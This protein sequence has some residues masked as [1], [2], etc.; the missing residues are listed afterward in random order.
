MRNH[1]PSPFGTL[2]IPGNAALPQQHPIN[3]NP[4]H[5]S[6]M[7]ISST[8]G[9]LGPPPSAL[10]RRVSVSA[11]SIEPST[12]PEIPP[13]FYFK[14]PQQMKRLE[15]SIA[16][17]FLFRNLDDKK[18]K[19]V[20]GAMKEMHFEKGV[21][22]ITQ[23]DQGDY[24]Y[25]VDSGELSC[26]V[27]PKTDEQPAYPGAPPPP[28]PGPPAPGDHPEYGKKVFQYGKGTSFGELALMYSSPRAATIIS[29]TP[30]TLW[31]LD[32][33]TFK[34][35][36]L[37]IASRTR[38]DYESFLRSVP[39]LNSLTDRERAKLADV[40]Q[41]RE[42]EEGDTVV[43][44]GEVGREFYI[45]EEGEAI[46]YKK[47]DE[48]REEPV[49]E[50]KRGD[51]FGELALLHRAPRAATVRAKP[52]SGKLKVATLDGDAFTRLLGPLREL[53]E[54]TAEVKYSSAT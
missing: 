36:L 45:I 5:R 30:V 19:A 9:Y 15:D 13:P 43:K 39:L 48:E 25:V 53:M 54:R 33:V 41:P 1:S 27:K 26:Y 28:P 34:T 11:E 23:G 7:P 16:N 52:G 4:I 6:P 49:M 50:M 35:I 22:V 44:E 20:L 47:I 3:T 37:E 29:D 12:G 18:R 8:E 32:R 42:F 46:A 14:A 24:F 31:A 51:Y 38:K 40:L 2:N 10:G 17:A 21:R